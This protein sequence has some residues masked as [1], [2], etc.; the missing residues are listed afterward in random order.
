MQPIRFYA[1]VEDTGL[2]IIFQ[3]TMNERNDQKGVGP[4]RY[5]TS[6]TDN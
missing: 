3:D 5:K 4:H 6:L 2:A 1:E